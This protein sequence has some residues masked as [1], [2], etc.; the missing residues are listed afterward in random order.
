MR[1]QLL[2]PAAG[3]GVRLGSDRPKALVLLA[4]RPLIAWTLER[5]AL[6]APGAVIVVP[7]G[8]AA[9]FDRAVREWCGGLAVTLVEGG[10]E[11]QISVAR[12]LAAL[13]PETDIVVIHDAARPFVPEAAVRESI[14]AAVAHGAA[15]VAIPSADTVLV[16]DSEGLLHD[17]PDR[18]LLWACQTPQTFR[19]AVIREAHERAARLGEEVTDDATL[20]RRAGG[21]VKLV[22]GSPLNMK[23]TTP[24]DLALA[25]AIIEG[26][27]A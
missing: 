11:R 6:Y 10:A 7:P 23:V 24:A 16:G 18:R 25:A 19:V 3:M 12:G 21:T 5:L 22:M 1:I 13:H 9:E 8:R 2:V 20:V 14:E 26:G 27:L 15:T 17:T 4:G